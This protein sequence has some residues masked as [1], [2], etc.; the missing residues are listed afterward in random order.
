VREQGRLSLAQAVHKMTGL[1]AAHVGLK[2]RGLIR[3]GYKA[4][5]VLFD[6]DRLVDRA[7]VA[8][9]TALAQGVATVLV[10]GQIVYANGK[11]AGVFPGTYLKRGQD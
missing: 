7:T 2:Q 1:S 6:A 8:D 3:P 11:P 9:P 10:D 4:D 5:L